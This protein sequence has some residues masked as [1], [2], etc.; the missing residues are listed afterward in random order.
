MNMRII[1]QILVLLETI[2]YQ[3]K[4]SKILHAARL[5]ILQTIPTITQFTI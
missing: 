2:S 1:A 3:Q 4:I 5:N